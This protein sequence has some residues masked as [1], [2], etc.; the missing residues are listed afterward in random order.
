MTRS[1]LVVLICQLLLITLC[2]S[3]A[4]AG[5]PQAGQVPQIVGVRVGFRGFYRVGTF[6][7]VEIYLAGVSR[8]AEPILRLSVPDGDGVAC[9]LSV[10]VVFTESLRHRRAKSESGSSDGAGRESA[11]REPATTG[12]SSTEPALRPVVANHSGRPNGDSGGQVVVRVPLRFGRLRGWVSAELISGG[13]V[14][15]QRTFRAGVDK[16]FPVAL[17]VAR[18]LFIAV[19]GDSLGVDEAIRLMREPEATRPVVAH[20]DRFD[21]LP[22]NWLAY[23]G[24]RAVVISTGHREVF[25]SRADP[26]GI[27]ESLH[28]W[29]RMGGTVV[30][31]LG[32]NAQSFLGAEASVPFDW[33]VGARLEGTVPFTRGRAATLENFCGSSAA[34]PVHT[35]AAQIPHLQEIDGVI[36]AA[37]GGLAMVVRRAVGFGQVRI[38]AGN[39][40]GAPLASWSDRGRLVA[41]L[42]DTPTQRR[43][44]FQR[45]TAV[46]HFGYDDMAGHLRSALDRF[47]GVRPVPFALIVA[48]LVLYIAVI[49]PVD[50]FLLHRFGRR[51]W[52]TWLTFPATVA[53]FCAVAWLLQTGFKNDR[54]L[55]H[56]ADLI[57]VDTTTGLVRGTTW[58]HVFSPRTGRYDFSFQPLLPSNQ[59]LDEARQ[60]LTWFGLPGQALG[61]MNPKTTDVAILQGHYDS[62]TEGLLRQV[63]IQ[64]GATKSFTVRWSATASPMI[65]ATLHEEDTQPVGTISSRLPVRLTDCMLVFGRYAFDLGDLEPGDTVVVGPR[66]PRRNLHAW[67]TGWHYVRGEEANDEFRAQA[68]PYDLAS[69]Q[70]PDILRIMMFYDAAGGQSY[71]RLANRYQPFVDS[72]ALLKAN[73]AILIGFA[74]SDNEQTFPGGTVPRCNGN[75]LSSEQVERTTAYRFVIPVLPAAAGNHPVATGQPER[76][77]QVA[78]IGRGQGDAG[79][80]CARGLRSGAAAGAEIAEQGSTT[81]T[82]NRVKL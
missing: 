41:S 11:G 49:G 32:H 47:Q 61:S 74:R 69:T 42:L 10:P 29:I 70:I 26:A 51:M 31:A 14:V 24:V 59:S 72:A 37:D 58:A 43:E 6:A 62:A 21:Q 7:P 2:Q 55:V 82:S 1:V 9:R 19:G 22:G 66:L 57:D 48:L 50:Y 30:L 77:V 15:A 18:E 33:L 73:R 38:L 17:P 46:M 54:V 44:Q 75:A 60:V 25:V 76:E 4:A 68:T 35:S 36:E 8:L 52:L 23:E 67:L 63:P 28:H 64:V 39:L 71:T 3:P 45:G 78:S 16:G 81:T 80:N 79:W 20:F 53:V 5:P 56:Q 27:I 13:K 12:P 34:I 40:D 65:E